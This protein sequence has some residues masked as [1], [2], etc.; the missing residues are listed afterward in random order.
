MYVEEQ[1]QR[2]SP[3]AGELDRRLLSSE[4]S[5]ADIVKWWNA[6]YCEW[7]PTLDAKGV[8]VLARSQIG[9]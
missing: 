2:G 1:R 3:F 4:E 8:E 6:K 5:L 9:R 7:R